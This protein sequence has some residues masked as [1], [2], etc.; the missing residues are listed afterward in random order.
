MLNAEA[1]Q[2]RLQQIQL[3]AGR[4]LVKPMVRRSSFIFTACILS[5]IFVG[6]MVKLVIIPGAAD[7]LCTAG[8]RSPN[9][10]VRIRNGHFAEFCRCDPDELTFK[11]PLLMRLKRLCWF[12][13]TDPVNGGRKVGTVPLK[14]TPHARQL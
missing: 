5:I 13:Y 9:A 12:P 1:D 2:Q 6:P 4:Q 8:C 11:C 10:F 14:K 7:P 3:N